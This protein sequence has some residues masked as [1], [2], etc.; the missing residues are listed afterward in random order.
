MI[1]LEV[2]ETVLNY[3]IIIIAE[4]YNNY[5]TIWVWESYLINFIVVSG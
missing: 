3:Q 4:Y 2:T 1:T 5:Y